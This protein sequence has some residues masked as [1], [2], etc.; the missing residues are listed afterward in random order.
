MAEQ[1]P[2][3]ICE[4]CGGPNVTWCAPND[5]WNRVARRQDGS[6]PMLCPRCFIIRA[7]AAGINKSAWVVMPEPIR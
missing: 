1:H 3:A 7:E 2:E 5:L 6:D 4:Q